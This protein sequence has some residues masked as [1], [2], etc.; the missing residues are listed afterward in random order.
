[1]GAGKRARIGRL[2]RPSYL[3]F[4]QYDA[5]QFGG[6]ITRG[7]IEAYAGPV[8][9]V[10]SAGAATAELEQ[11]L[12]AATDWTVRAIDLDEAVVRAARSRS[13]PENLT[14]EV[15]DVCKPPDRE[16]D[17]AL[18]FGSVQE[19][20]GCPVDGLRG[21]REA[22]RPGGVALIAVPNVT[23]M[24][25]VVRPDCFRLD[26]DSLDGGGRLVA[27]ELGL[28]DG[29]DLS[30]YGFTHERQSVPAAS[31]DGIDFDLGALTPFEAL[32]ERA[33][34][35]PANVEPL[36]EWATDAALRSV[37]GERVD[38]FELAVGDRFPV[39]VPVDPGGLVGE[40]TGTPIHRQV[41]SFDAEAAA[42]LASPI[43]EM[44]LERYRLAQARESD[45]PPRVDFYAFRRVG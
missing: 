15:G 42:A 2:D 16:H 34:F 28:P 9:A 33:G 40:A 29:T 27:A 39:S 36:A 5:R 22:L 19:L 13:L 43:E 25:Q 38:G 4:A 23:D 30:Q 3:S 10:Y 41:E 8:D 20:V 14:V 45:R 17:V 7:M 21:L 26:E 18:A 1:M 24:L 12:A 37:G 31:A 6:A 32:A 11:E 44:G 35:R